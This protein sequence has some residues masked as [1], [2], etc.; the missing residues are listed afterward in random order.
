MTVYANLEDA[1]IVL[2]EAVLAGIQAATF[3]RLTAGATARQ[4]LSLLINPPN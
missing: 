2:D 1:V 4:L 3:V